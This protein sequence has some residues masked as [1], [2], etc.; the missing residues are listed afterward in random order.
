MTGPDSV[1]VVDSIEGLFSCRRKPAENI[2]LL[3]RPISGCFNDLAF[4]LL[5]QNR[6][7]DTLVADKSH[8]METIYKVED[9]DTF[10]KNDT[11]EWP[12]ELDQIRDDMRVMQKAVGYR[13]ELRVVRGRG[14]HPETHRFHVDGG[15]YR[16]ALQAVDRVMCCYNK[17]TTEWVR[18]EDA[19]ALPAPSGF[20]CFE[21]KKDAPV[22][23]FG[24]GD[25]WRQACVGDRSDALVHRAADTG[26]HDP[27][28]LL[29]VC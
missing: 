23:H 4:W 25:I 26:P 29:V 11:M 21:K 14:Y 9:L 5:K 17:P 10:A 28:R 24:V 18:K 1:A 8:Y 7:H 19:I 20:Q 12:E 15:A 2:V 13:A 6:W 16:S 3:P 22:F 27:P